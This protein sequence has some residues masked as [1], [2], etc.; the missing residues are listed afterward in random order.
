L[1]FESGQK[2]RKQPAG[3]RERRPPTA[4]SEHFSADLTGPFC[5]EQEGAELLESG[6]KRELS[7]ADSGREIAAPDASRFL[8]RLQYLVDDGEAARNP[9]RGNGFAGDHAVAREQLLGDGRT[10]FRGARHRC[11]LP[12]VGRTRHR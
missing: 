6:G 2:R 3:T 9:F 10:P 7:G 11:R 5:V 1:D 12:G 4:L 8:A